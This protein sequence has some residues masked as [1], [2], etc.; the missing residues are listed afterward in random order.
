LSDKNTIFKYNKIIRNHNYNILWGGKI[1]PRV[2]IRIPMKVDAKIE[3]IIDS[4]IWR[5]KSQF[6]LEAIVEKI[7]K[8]E[9]PTLDPEVEII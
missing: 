6:I 3:E 7:R 9:N 4:G 8:T 5:N 1:K 2:T